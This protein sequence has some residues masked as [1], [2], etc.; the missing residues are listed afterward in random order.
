[1]EMWT[2]K[3]TYTVGQKIHILLSTQSPTPYNVLFNA[4]GMTLQKGQ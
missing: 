1:M 3:I 4:L 2:N